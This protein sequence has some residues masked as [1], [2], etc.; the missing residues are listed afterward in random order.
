M[1]IWR[2]DKDQEATFF[3]LCFYFFGVQYQ[4]WK[5][6]WIFLSIQYLLLDLAFWEVL[7][8][9]RTYLRGKLSLWSVW[10][11]VL[12]MS[13]N[14]PL[15]GMGSLTIFP[16]HFLSL[17]EM[18]QNYW[19]YKG[20]LFIE[21]PLHSWSAVT[22]QREAVIATA[23]SIPFWPKHWSVEHYIIG[24]RI[25]YHIVCCKNASEAQINYSLL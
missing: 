3:F 14:L 9:S 15:L 6:S 11:A 8:S 18:S 5:L 19:Q 7:N 4:R 24:A 13:L 16:P 21:F 23:H 12:I 1:R 17:A 25:V 10:V 20:G 2:L 22:D